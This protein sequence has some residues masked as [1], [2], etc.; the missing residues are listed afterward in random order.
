MAQEQWKGFL[1]PVERFQLGSLTSL[2]LCGKRFTK[3]VLDEWSKY[4]DLSKLRTLVLEHV[5][6]TRALIDAATDARFR[7][8]ERLAIYLEPRHQYIGFNVRNVN[9]RPAVEDFFN[10]I[11]SLKSLRLYGCSDFPLAAQILARHGSTLRELVLKGITL[12]SANIE[13]I[14]DHCPLLEDFKLSIERSKSDNVET[15]CYEALGR[16]ASLVELELYLECSEPQRHLDEPEEDEDN[17][18][19]QVYTPDPD[20]CPQVYYSH[21]RDALVN[22]AIDKALAI[23][24]WDIIS[25]NRSGRALERLRINSGGG[26]CLGGT[27]ADYLP[28]R[29]RHMSR[30]FQLTK[31]ERDDRNDV[32]I[33]EIGGGWRKWRDKNEREKEAE[34][35]KKGIEY[36]GYSKMKSLF[37]RLWPPKS[38]SLDWRDD[39]SSYP[40]Q[41]TP[42]LSSLC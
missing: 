16:F 11:Y 8:L 40:L 26:D 1:P 7:S 28:E 14:G 12:T 24:I 10:S 42:S 23:S 20:G 36:S 18:Y 25:A 41:T 9:F 35:I 17:F 3:A 32:R 37:E 5:V 34:M 27:V 4:T 19:R 6:S 31:S 15:K 22:S 39:W 29:A 13:V 33:Y 21:V 38:G 2:S 30:S